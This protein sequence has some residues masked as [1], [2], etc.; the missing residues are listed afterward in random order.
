MR[1]P[2][3]HK[4]MLRKVQAVNSGKSQVFSSVF[5]CEKLTHKRVKT[6]Y[7]H[8]KNQRAYSNEVIRL[9]YGHGYSGAHISRILPIT[10]STVS[11]WLSI[12]ASENEET[13]LPMPKLESKLDLETSSCVDSQVSEVKALRGEIARLQIRLKEERLRADAYD[14]MINVAESMFKISIR[15]KAVANTS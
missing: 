8:T 14:E 1:L 13:P 5:P 9:H 11:R 15:K 12:F 10:S 3:P 7:L 4:I 2:C 6:M